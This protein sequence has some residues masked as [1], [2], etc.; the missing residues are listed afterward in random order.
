MQRTLVL[1]SLLVSIGLVVSGL[2]S[3]PNASALR[4]LGSGTLANRVET[5]LPVIL[6][7]PIACW[8]WLLALARAS[9]ATAPQGIVF[10]VAAPLFALFCRGAIATAPSEGIGYMVIIYFLAAWVAYPVLGLANQ[11]K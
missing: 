6:L 11:H 4:Q 2:L 3:N 8:P 5:A 7:F 9:A 1:L 10:A